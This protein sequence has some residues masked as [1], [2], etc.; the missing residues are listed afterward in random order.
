[1]RFGGSE[2]KEVKREGGKGGK[3]GRKGGEEGRDGW[4]EERM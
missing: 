2:E 4:K 1:M 3:E